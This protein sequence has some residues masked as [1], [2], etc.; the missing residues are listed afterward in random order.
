MGFRADAVLIMAGVLIN[1]SKL[2]V[3]ERE[4]GCHSFM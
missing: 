4:R 2:R 3:G 1:T